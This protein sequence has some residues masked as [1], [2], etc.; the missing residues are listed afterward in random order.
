MNTLTHTQKCSR[1][2]GFWDGRL[3]KKLG[4]PAPWQLFGKPHFDKDYEEGFWAGFNGQPHPVTGITP[5]E[6]C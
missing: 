6:T 1:N 5:A 3:Q 4:K 2:Y